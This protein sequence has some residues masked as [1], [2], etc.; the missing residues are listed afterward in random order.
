M[1]TFKIIRKDGTALEIGD[2]VYTVSGRITIEEGKLARMD[3]TNWTKLREV[4]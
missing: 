1:K 4:E 2:G 3:N